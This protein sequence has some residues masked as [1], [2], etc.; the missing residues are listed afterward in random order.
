MNYTL[1]TIP[2]AAINVQDRIRQDYGDISAIK[3]SLTKF[4]LIHP[5]AVQATTIDDNKYRLIAGGR[6]LLA[7]TELGWT[8]IEAKVFIGEMTDKELKVVELEENIRRKDLTPYEEMM[9]L[10]EFQETME[11]IKGKGKSKDGTGHS[12]RDTAT[13]LGRSVSSVS[14]ELAVAE[15]L[16]NPLIGN[17]AKKAK[18]KT[19]MF[20]LVAIMK[21]EIILS[22]LSKRKQSKTIDTPE[23]ELKQRLYDSYILM[24]SLDYTHTISSESIDL[25]EA[26]PDYGIGIKSLKKLTENTGINI[27]DYQE[28]NSD[29]INIMSD[30]IYEWYRILKSD[31]WC[32]LWHAFQYENALRNIARQA[33][34]QVGEVPAFWAKEGGGQS[35]QPSV[36][37]ASSV[38]QFLYLRKGK[39]ILNKPGRSNLFLYNPINLQEK[40]SIHITARPISMMQDIIYTFCKF[41]TVFVPFLGSGNTL[42]AISNI[43]STPILNA[44]ITA[45][46]C[47]ISEQHRQRFIIRV[48]EQKIGDFK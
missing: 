3:E 10:K 27:N 42:L 26:D 14:T 31:G 39:A 18:T 47:D 17:L 36:S 9:S 43:V 40:G 35:K 24:D 5:V 23:E 1:A 7:A 37:L 29:Y 22:E 48:A 2:I 20:K 4:G 19:D 28:I 44:D 33:G 34:F 41:G 30:Y 46:G 25:I 11:S 8:D 32:I 45:F 38:E 21:E 12:I 13:M 15:A 6:R 16:M